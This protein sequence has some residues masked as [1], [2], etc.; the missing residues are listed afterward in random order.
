MSKEEKSES[1]KRQAKHLKQESD[2][3]I[4]EANKLNGID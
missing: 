3:L 4:K 1:L 2:R